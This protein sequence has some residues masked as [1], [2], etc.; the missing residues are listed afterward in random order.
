MIQNA[1]PISS[2]TNSLSHSMAHH[3]YH[4]HLNRRWTMNFVRGRLKMWKGQGVAEDWAL[5]LYAWQHSNSENVH[6]YQDDEAEYL[7]KLVSWLSQNQQLTMALYWFCRK[8][9]YKMREIIFMWSILI[10]FLIIWWG[11]FVN[12]VIL[13]LRTSK[14]IKIIFL[15]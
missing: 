6:G 10:I 4:R 12:Y 11:D 8:K 1:F 5:L 7:G 13:V 14:Y 15:T 2:L 3:P 9:C